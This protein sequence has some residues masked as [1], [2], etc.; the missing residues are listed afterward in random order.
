MRNNNVDLA[1]MR[2]FVA[3]VE[4]GSFSAAARR[5]RVGQPA[6]SK[7]ISRL[8]AD[9]GAALLLRSTRS[10][11]VTDA[12]ER[13]YEGCIETLEA[14]E[15]AEQAVREES[16]SDRGAIRVQIPE[17]LW[18]GSMPA[19]FQDFRKDSPGIELT[20][21]TQLEETAL[22]ASG[23]DIG[24][25]IGEPSIPDMVARK[26]GDTRTAL[27][28][29]PSLVARWSEAGGSHELM[30]A[31]AIHLANR[32][33][34]GRWTFAEGGARVALSARTSILVDT[35]GAALVA[36]SAGFG[37]WWTTKI[38]VETELQKG[39]LTE[40]LPSAMLPRPVYFLC[41]AGRRR[42]RRVDRFADFL[43]DRLQRMIE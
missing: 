5:L 38:E 13:Y 9:L 27:I 26:L 6:V 15:R 39:N 24:M 1:L 29:Q 36:A 28:G 14:A 43:S 21:F 18:T 37:F 42:S 33:D 11:Q 7:A 30:D 3:V 35:P 31:P 4:A 8:E 20:V 23:I 17:L 40:L 16:E 22:L 41:P 2:Q 10:V 25:L 19:Q 12:G 32:A 34:G